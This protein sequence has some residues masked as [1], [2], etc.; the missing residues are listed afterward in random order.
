MKGIGRK[1][2][3]VAQ[4]DMLGWTGKVK[5][6]VPGHAGGKGVVTGDNTKCPASN[7]E[8]DATEENI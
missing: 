6:G 3:A 2:V 1:D 5:C 4:K 7:S 8:K